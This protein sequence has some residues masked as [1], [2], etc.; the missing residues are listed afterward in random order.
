[1]LQCCSS[2]LI[3][4]ANRCGRQSR[5]K[6]KLAFLRGVS[7]AVFPCCTVLFQNTASKSPSLRTPCRADSVDGHLRSIAMRI[8]RQG[9]D[10]A[11]PVPLYAC[12]GHS[13]C[14]CLPVSMGGCLSC[15]WMIVSDFVVCSTL[16]KPK[17]E[18]I[19]LKTGLVYPYK[20]K[21]Y[22]K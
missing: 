5:S 3:G 19:Q 9:I 2:C 11:V 18:E 12:F 13:F 1:M 7:S 16:Q 17:P 8:L 20:P 10:T 15:I 21:L 22:Q 14:S 4:W 6:R